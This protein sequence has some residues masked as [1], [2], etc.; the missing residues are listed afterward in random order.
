[1]LWPANPKTMKKIK[2]GELFRHLGGFLSSK[3]IELKDGAYAKRIEQ[4]CQ[5]LT[6]AINVSQAGLEKAKLETGKKLDRVRQVIHEKT[7]PKAAAA[8]TPPPVRAAS[9]RPQPKQ[10]KQPARAPRSPAAKPSRTAGKSRSAG[11]KKTPKR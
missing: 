5:V 9:P 2:T 3:G 4:G 11:S 6:N 8:P 10:S 1:M 7:S